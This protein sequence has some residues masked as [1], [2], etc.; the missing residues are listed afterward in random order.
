[1]LSLCSRIVVPYDD[2]ELSRKALEKAILLAK[3]DEK[4][5]LDVLHVVNP[6]IFYNE[7]P[8]YNL[9]QLQ[10]IQREI[11]EAMIFELKERLADLRNKTRTFLVEGN[12]GQMILEFVKKNDADLIV[13]GCRGLG[14]LKG[15]FL[16]SVSHYV[17]QKAACP[18]MIVK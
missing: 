7:S 18:V 11:G 4:I 15:A 13:M 14:G 3:Q 6:I 12:P 16:G 5:E 17:V 1:M 8:I 2:S 10:E 9:E